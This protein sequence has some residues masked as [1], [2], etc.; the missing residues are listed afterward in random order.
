MNPIIAVAVIL[1]LVL[2]TGL[3][4]AM[5]LVDLIPDDMLGPDGRQHRGASRR[6][7]PG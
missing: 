5:S 4:A 3:F 2:F 6:G 7:R 1:T